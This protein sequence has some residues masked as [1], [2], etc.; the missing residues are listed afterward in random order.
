M[1]VEL[2]RTYP[3]SRGK[4]FAYFMDISTW[5]DWTTLTILDADTTSWREPGDVVNYTYATPIAGVP[6]KGSAV[7]DEVTP[8]ELVKMRL[9]TAGLPDTP[10]ECRFGHSGPGAFTLTLTVHTEDPAGFFAGALQQITM[11]ETFVA[12]DM[13]KCLDGLERSVNLMK[14][15]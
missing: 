15:A 13:R 7:L 9:R 12:R 1:H 4:G 8:E 6:L 3:L 11:M 2:S 5:D 10:V 14:V